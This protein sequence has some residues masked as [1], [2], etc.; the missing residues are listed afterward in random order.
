MKQK[1]CFYST[2]T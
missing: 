1:A 2:A